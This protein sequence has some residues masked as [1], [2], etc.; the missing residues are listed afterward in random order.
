MIPAKLIQ[1]GIKPEKSV[2]GRTIWSSFGL[3]LERIRRRRG[4][5]EEN[6]RDSSESQSEQHKPSL[7]V[8]S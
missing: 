8:R 3:A 2:P 1:R 6:F 4:L 7:K 5:C